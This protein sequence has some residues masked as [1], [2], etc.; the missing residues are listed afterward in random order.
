MDKLY[1]IEL[2]E[3]QYGPYTLGQ[4]RSFGLLPDVLVCVPSVGDEWKQAVEYD[5]LKDLF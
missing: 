5:E 2:D 4:V 1:Y 3:Q